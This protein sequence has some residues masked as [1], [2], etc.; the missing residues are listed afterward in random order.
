[1]KESLYA[2]A[3]LDMGPFLVT[4]SNPIHQLMD[5]IQTIQKYQVLNWTRKLCATNY[6]IMLTFNRDKLGWLNIYK[7]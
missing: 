1:M 7:S 5:P 6:Y 4:Q 2:D 3:E